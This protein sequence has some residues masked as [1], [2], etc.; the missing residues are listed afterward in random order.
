MHQLRAL[1]VLFKAAE[2][3]GLSGATAG[4]VIALQDT[5]KSLLHPELQLGVR[6]G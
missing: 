6:L 5:S 4:Q 1:Q 3:D 2:L